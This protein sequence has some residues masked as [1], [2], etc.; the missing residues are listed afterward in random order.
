MEFGN[1]RFRCADVLGRGSYGEVW[2]AQA[3]SPGRRVAGSPGR[4]ALR[5]HRFDSA[6]EVLSAKGRSEPSEVALKEVL[7]RS[8]SELRQASFRARTETKPD[9]SFSV[10]K[11]EPPRKGT[12]WGGVTYR[13]TYF[14]D[15]FCESGGGG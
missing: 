2:R 7:C 6:A 14:R 11:W 15:H 8:Q 10:L 12:G 9:A 5:S 1:F 13:A 4:E 3:G